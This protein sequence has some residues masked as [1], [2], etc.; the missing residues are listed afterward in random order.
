MYVKHEFE[1]NKCS[2]KALG[3][4]FGLNTIRLHIDISPHSSNDVL[5]YTCM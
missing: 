5:N 4:C 2:L 1:A 3:K